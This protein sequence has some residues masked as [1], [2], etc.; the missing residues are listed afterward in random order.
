ML[1]LTPMRVKTNTMRR[2]RYKY[3]FRGTQDLYGSDRS[4]WSWWNI[5]FLCSANIGRWFSNSEINVFSNTSIYDAQLHHFH[6]QLPSLSS[7]PT[8]VNCYLLL[9][10]S[11]CTFSWTNCALGWRNRW[12]IRPLKVM[13]TKFWTGPMKTGGYGKVFYALFIFIIKCDWYAHHQWN[14]EE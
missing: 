9:S 13:G 5:N 14:S 6:K 1:P 10:E 7:F 12:I 2:L 11:I 4:R 8:L 3:V